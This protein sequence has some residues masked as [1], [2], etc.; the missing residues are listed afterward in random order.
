VTAAP[1]QPAPER[2]DLPHGDSELWT[3]ALQVTLALAHADPHA[4]DITTGQGVR[5]ALCNATP[6][7]LAL[8]LT[9]SQHSTSCPWR[10]ARDVEDR[11]NKGRAASPNEAKCVRLA[12]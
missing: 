3:D 5:C 10:A 12:P 7:G 1:Y 8:T 11:L 4:F 9:E 6:P 2:P